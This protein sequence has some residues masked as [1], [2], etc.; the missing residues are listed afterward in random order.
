MAV[1][2]VHATMRRAAWSRA[3]TLRGTGTGLAAAMAGSSS[4]CKPGC[5]GPLLACVCV[6]C[7]IKLVRAALGSGCAR[8][9]GAA[10]D[11]WCR[12]ALRMP[13]VVGMPMPWLQEA[14][15]PRTLRARLP[16]THTSFTHTCRALACACVPA[17]SVFNLFQKLKRPRVHKRGGSGGRGGGRSCARRA[18]ALRVRDLLALYLG[19]LGSARPLCVRVR[20]R[21]LAPRPRRSLDGHRRAFFPRSA[22]SV[23]RRIL[24]S[25]VTL[26]ATA[27]DLMARY[28]CQGL[29]AEGETAS[30]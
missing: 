9:C 20:G 14:W 23:D 15:R 25:P 21:C 27:C 18:R 2:V 7:L 11:A 6:C 26:R 12:H 17:A 5:A 10:W 16:H 8:Q 1:G 28:G 22:R 30:G 24:P 19:H 13:Y 29:G 3:G 4:T